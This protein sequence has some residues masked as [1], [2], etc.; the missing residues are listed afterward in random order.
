MTETQPAL[1][2]GHGSPM[3]ALERNRHTEALRSFSA[4]RSRPRAI[5][6]LSAH[7]YTHGTHV[8]AMA[9]PRTIHDFGGFPQALFD[10]QYPAPGAPELAAEIAGLLPVDVTL[11]QSWGLDHGTWQVL[12]HLY[13]EADIPV[14]QLSIDQK[15]TPAQHI[16]FGRR[17]ARLRDQGVMILGSGNVVHNLSVMDW[18]KAD[19]GFDWADRYSNLTRDRFL[20][21]DLDGLANFLDDGTDADQS[22]PTAEHYLP[23]LYVAGAVRSTDKLSVV[24]DGLVMG[25]LSMLSLVAQ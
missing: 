8:T 1:F 14:L 3:N 17:L 10:V 11:D 18:Q 15:A 23:L 7:W 21:R 13:P 5:L 22:I 19:G 24:T 6:S 25:S 20:N 9:E 16:E 12:I 4:S 2:V